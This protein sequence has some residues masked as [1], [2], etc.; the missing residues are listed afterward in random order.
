MNLLKP[1]SF[2]LLA[3]ILISSCA[4]EYSS[5][6]AIPRNGIWQFSKGN[7]QYAGYVQS[8]YVTNGGN[9]NQLVLLG[10][11]NDGSQTFQLTV[12]ADTIKIGTY[13]ASQFQSSLFYGTS[14]IPIYRAGEQYGE[15]IVNLTKLDS[16]SIL[17]NFSGTVQDSSYNSMQIT[18]GKFQVQ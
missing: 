2:A 18:N 11:S 3:C 5:E 9:S 14:Q 10:K 12:Y 1:I 7:A 8:I 13:K 15:F 6:I 4:K 16:T 17:G